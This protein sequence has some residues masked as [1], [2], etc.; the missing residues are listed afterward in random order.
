MKIINAKIKNVTVG[1]DNG[2]RLSARMTFDGQCDCRDWSFI[3]TNPTDV[4]RLMKLMNYAG[5]YKVGDLND[6][7]IRVVYHSILFCG[8]GDPIKDKFV[9]TSMEEFKEINEAEFEELLK[10]N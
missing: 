7:I 1:L 10:N 5:V 6:K 4:Q 9:P 2:D 8:Y 3:L